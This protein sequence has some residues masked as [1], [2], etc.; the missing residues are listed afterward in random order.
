MPDRVV[1]ACKDKNFEDCLKLAVEH[2]AGLEL[3]MFAMPHVLDG[4]WQADAERYQKKFAKHK[5]DGPLSMHGAF[6]DLYSAS[7][8]KKVVAL[9]RE[10]Y[11]TNLAIAETFKAQYVVFHANFLASIRMPEYRDQWVERQIDFWGD[12]VVQAKKRG[13]T[14]LLENM[15][16]YDPAILADVLEGVNSP[17]LKTC[18]DVGHTF[19]FSEILFENWVERLERWLVYTH[20]NNNPGGVDYHLAL[21]EGTIDYSKVLAKLRSLSN[22]PTFCLE[23]ESVDDIKRSLPLFERAATKKKASAKKKAKA[24]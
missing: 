12:L 23:I 5:F 2:G 17:H 10:R 3:Q 18:I 20:L 22:P 7:P 14:M 13:V 9:A 24:S 1:I 16:E 6:L 19:L 11:T 8:D 4:D 15:W 21:G